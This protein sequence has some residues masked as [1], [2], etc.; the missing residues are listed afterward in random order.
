MPIGIDDNHTLALTNLIDKSIEIGL[1][2]N[3]KKNALS[4]G[5]ISKRSVNNFDRGFRTVKEGN[6]SN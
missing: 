2:F 1:K 3:F 6:L 4:K 5:Y